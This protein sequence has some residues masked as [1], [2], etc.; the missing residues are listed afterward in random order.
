MLLNKVVSSL[1]NWFEKLH[2][3]NLDGEHMLFSKQIY[4]YKYNRYIVI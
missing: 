3:L 2:R 4:S 1:G